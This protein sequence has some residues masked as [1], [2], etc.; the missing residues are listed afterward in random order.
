MTNLEDAG[1]TALARKIADLAL[2]RT[3]IGMP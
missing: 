2:Q 1:L 3:D